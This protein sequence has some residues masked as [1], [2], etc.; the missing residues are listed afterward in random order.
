LPLGDPMDL[1]ALTKQTIPK[2]EKDRRNREDLCRYCG[3]KGHYAKECPKA[4]QNTVKRFNQTPIRRPS[5][6]KIGTTYR[7]LDYN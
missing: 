3:D 1:G 4:P 7:D 5:N 2:E 6:F